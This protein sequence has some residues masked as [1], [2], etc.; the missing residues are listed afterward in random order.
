MKWKR[1]STPYCD[2][3]YFS[4][5]TIFVILTY[6]IIFSLGVLTFWLS[7]VLKSKT[8]CNMCISGHHCG[9]QRLIAKEV[10]IFVTFCSLI[11]LLAPPAW[12]F[13]LYF[14]VCHHM[15]SHG[16]WRWRQTANGTI[17]PLNRDLT[18]CNGLNF[19]RV[20]M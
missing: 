9:K 17:Q 10:H 1:L 6:S 16:R 20:S 18:G 4:I 8:L 12:M 3:V 7:V 11:L 15:Y 19:L 2:I 13:S 14:S 5:G